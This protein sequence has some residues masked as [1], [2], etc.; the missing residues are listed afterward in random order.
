MRWIFVVEEGERGGMEDQ[1]VSSVSMLDREGGGGGVVDEEACCCCWVVV[2]EEA[3]DNFEA[4]FASRTMDFSILDTDVRTSV[5][6]GE[7][8]R[9]SRVSFI[10][11]MSERRE[12]MIVTAGEGWG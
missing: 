1:E 3:E 11:V 5:R 12:D 9:A 10:S 4:I 2:A 6:V 8:G 7:G